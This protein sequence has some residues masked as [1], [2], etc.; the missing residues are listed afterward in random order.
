MI[1]IQ[2][3]EKEVDTLTRY[4]RQLHNTNSRLEKEMEETKKLLVTRD[5]VCYAGTFVH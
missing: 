3:A 1:I 2:D 5:Q 4:K